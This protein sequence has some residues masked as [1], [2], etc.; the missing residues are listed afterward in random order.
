M[1]TNTTGHG[2]HRFLPIL[3]KTSLQIG[4]YSFWYW[5]DMESF[6]CA[7]QPAHRGII[8]QKIQTYRWYIDTVKIITSQINYPWSAGK[9]LSRQFYYSQGQS[10]SVMDNNMDK[11]YGPAFGLCA[12]QMPGLKTSQWD[13]L[14]DGSCC[15]SV[16]HL[17]KMVRPFL[18]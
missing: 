8:S 13:R 5:S 14:V 11:T 10:M 6:L 1:V 15:L 12:A 2:E 18:Q 9:R 3:K 4:Q 16:D 17:M 7:F